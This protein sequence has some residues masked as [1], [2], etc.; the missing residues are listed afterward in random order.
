M[1]VLFTF[2]APGFWYFSDENDSFDENP[3]ISGN[4][5]CALDSLC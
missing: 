4:R 3:Q 2:Y 5:Q 1:R